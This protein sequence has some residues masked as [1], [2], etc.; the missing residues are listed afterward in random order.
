MLL[1]PFWRL[2]PDSVF[3]VF[4]T[5]LGMSDTR[6]IK[7]GDK[8][9]NLLCDVEMIYDFLSISKSK[10]KLPWNFRIEQNLGALEDM[11]RA[12]KLL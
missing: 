7:E 6:W 11:R 8:K 4:N 3:L 10:I 5:F 2:S 9:K 1:Y 12:E